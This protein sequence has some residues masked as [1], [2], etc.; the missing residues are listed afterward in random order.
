MVTVLVELVP[1][2]IRLHQMHEMQTIVTNVCDVCQS[3]HPSVCP[4]CCSLVCGAFAA[5]FAKLLW[6][7]AV[8][9]WTITEDN[10]VQ[11]VSV[12]SAHWSESVS[13][14]LTSHSTLYKSFRGR[15]LRAR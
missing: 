13:R 10:S 14:G 6:L 5:T 4:S 11:G 15:F 2:I 9:I 12:L 7:P 8:L 1:I 3:V